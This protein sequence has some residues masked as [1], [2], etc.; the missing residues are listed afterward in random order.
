MLNIDRYTD[1]GDHMQYATPGTTWTEWSEDNADRDEA[2]KLAALREI[3]TVTAHEWVNSGEITAEWANKKLAKLGIADRLDLQNAYVLETTVVAPFKA[4]VYAADRAAAEDQFKARLTHALTVAEAE[5]PYALRFVSGPE[6]APQAGDPDAP[7]TIDATLTMLREIILLANVSGP[8]FNCDSGASR[9]LASYG[10]APVPE[11]K[12][13]TV[14][15]PAAVDMVTTVEAY[16]EAS[17]LRIADWRWE[18]GHK[19]FKASNVDP[20]DDLAV[21]PVAVPADN[22]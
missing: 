22:A 16:D 15:R 1:G 6:D 21:V 8:R 11:R 7:T 2:T 14:R 13:F 5:A 4:T 3:I 17:A 19:D 9:V 20:I 18:D 12:K 10:L